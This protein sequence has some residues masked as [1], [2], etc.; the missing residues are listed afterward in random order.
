MS[1][2]AGC[3]EGGKCGTHYEYGRGCRCQP[4]TTAHAETV[5]ETRQG[6]EA[7]GRIHRPQD[8]AALEC[9]CGGLL[10][11]DNAGRVYCLRCEA[12][13]S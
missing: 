7:V 11:E 12:I 13:A 2:C 10:A 4:C 1:E 5:D 3:G 6:R 9:E 8:T